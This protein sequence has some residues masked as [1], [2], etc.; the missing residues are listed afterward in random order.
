[1][2]LTLDLTFISSTPASILTTSGLASLSVY[3][4]GFLK[5]IGPIDLHR[6]RSGDS[7]LAYFVDSHLVQ[8]VQYVILCSI[9]SLW[10]SYSRISLL[11]IRLVFSLFPTRPGQQTSHRR[12]IVYAIL[13]KMMLEHRHFVKR[14]RPA[15]RTATLDERSRKVT[16]F[17]TFI[18]EERFK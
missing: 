8:D 1:L 10:L 11:S 6:V 12:E 18:M 7:P 16:A 3:H 4:I 2:I 17:A 5:F 14:L 13:G 9:P 15:F